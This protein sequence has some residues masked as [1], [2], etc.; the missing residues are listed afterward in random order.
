MNSDNNQTE[1][2]FEMPG[3]PQQ[4]TEA[5][6]PETV[7]SNSDGQVQ[8]NTK[9]PQTD[10]PLTTTEMIYAGL[11][12]LILI[13]LGYGVY[14][15]YDA[16][17]G[18]NLP[19]KP[20]VATDVSKTD[21][22]NS[23]D[24]DVPT[25]LEAEQQEESISE[26]KKTLTKSSEQQATTIKQIDSELDQISESH[27]ISSDKINAIQN[28]LNEMKSLYKKLQSNVD[29]LASQIEDMKGSNTATLTALQKVVDNQNQNTVVVQHLLSLQKKEEAKPAPKKE[30]HIVALVD[31]R[32]WLADHQGHQYTFVVGDNLPGYGKITGINPV[33]STVTISDGTI[34]R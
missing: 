34:I 2:K 8:D 25:K 9:V 28:E 6:Q 18:S 33:D 7:D 19:D 1:E 10:K 12:I 15:L 13:G 23:G 20:I 17:F 32:A 5:I 22:D 11:M 21:D 31:G 26:L 16:F 14:A 24:S 29:N 3:S 30:F 4:T 27:K